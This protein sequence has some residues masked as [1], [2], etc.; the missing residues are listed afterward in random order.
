MSRVTSRLRLVLGAAIVAVIG[1]CGSSGY[2]AEEYGG[3]VAV[4]SMP[5]EGAGGEASVDVVDTETSVTSDSEVV[6]SPDAALET[7]RQLIYVAEVRLVV[8]DFAALEG[9]NGL[10]QLIEKHGGHTADLS[11]DRNQGRARS[12]HW[13]ARIPVKN[14]RIF[15]GA[16]TELGVPE[17]F[18]ETTE[19]VTAQYVDLDARIRN[20]KRLEERILQ[21]LERSAGKINELIEVER[22]LGRVRGEIERMDSMFRSLQSRIK[23]TTVTIDVREERDYEPPQAPS[24]GSRIGKAWTSSILAISVA[25]KNLLVGLVAVIPWLIL[26]IPAGLLLRMIWR[27]WRGT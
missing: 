9:K 16:L 15:L 14:Y 21:L 4:N 1:G 11:I 19:D 18:R 10:S 12:G 8:E 6:E 20:K 24:F 13:K 5:L 27:R 3:G 22:E 17:H 2:L 7:E 26:A 23:M 25:A